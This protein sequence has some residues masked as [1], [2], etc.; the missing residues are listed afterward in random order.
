MRAS[1]YILA[2]LAIMLIASACSAGGGNQPPG[3]IPPLPPVSQPPE[4]TPPTTPPTTVPPTTPPTTD[5]S[6]P[7]NRLDDITPAT[8]QVF[9]A[10]NPVPV[11]ADP[12]DPSRILTRF[13]T[14]ERDIEATGRRA[15]STSIVWYEITLTG[16]SKAWVDS[17]WLVHEITDLAAEKPDTFVVSGLSAGDR[18]NV[19]AHPGVDHDAVTTLAAGAAVDTTGR[20]AQVQGAV[21]VEVE[22]SATG[23]GWVNASFLTP[24]VTFLADEAPAVYQVT[25]LD[26]GNRLNVRKGPGTHSDVITTLAANAT[27]IATTGKRAEVSGGLWR[28]IELSDGTLG[29]VS[30]AFVEPQPEPAPGACRPGGDTFCPSLGAN[31]G[32]AAAFIARA[33]GLSGDGGRDWFT[34]DNGSLFEADINRLAAA[35]VIKGCNPPANDR[36][37][38]DEPASRAMVAAWFSRA[39]GLTDDGGRDWF[40]DDNGSLFE[41]DINR[42]AAAGIVKACNPPAND[43]VCP[44]ETIVRGQL[45]A[46]TVRAFNI[47]S[48]SKDF[49]V[50]DNDSIF[51][52]AI[53][54]IAAANITRP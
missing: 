29:W 40:T 49:F 36:I 35:G 47:P 6:V 26:E 25:G 41:A 48:T 34:D 24:E 22:Y 30:D 31:R 20:R 16:G 7:V 38:P 10:V 50:D 53:N 2:V 46:W 9:G 27:D 33:M 52:D 11:I 18:L 21:W 8:Y 23:K 3:D 54:A 37:C 17:T 42:L 19:R 14:D 28:Q 12:S 1:R 39:L 44:D 5:P 43:K 15:E 4:T 32:T 45:A 51:E 13:A